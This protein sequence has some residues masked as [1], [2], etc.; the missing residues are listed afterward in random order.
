[1][2]VCVE[3]TSQCVFSER[4]D[5][6]Y[7]AWSER[8]ESY[9]NA[10]YVIDD[11]YKHSYRGEVFLV[12]DGTEKVYV[13]SMEYST[14]DSFGRSE[15]ELAIIHCTANED[16]AHRLA[17]KITKNSNEFT[18]NFED[19]FGR[20]IQI[21]NPGAGYFESID[22]VSVDAF[23]VGNYKQRKYYVQ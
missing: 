22:C 18:I 16:A 5:A 15:G 2:K 12:P 20:E 19:D 11:S 17:K 1:M 10:V 21:G 4:E 13:V 6:P 8:L 23:D 7:G 14:G 3:Y 9:I